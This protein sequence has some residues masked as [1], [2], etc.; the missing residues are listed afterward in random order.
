MIPGRFP[1]LY[2]S[3]ARSGALAEITYHWSLISPPPSKPVMVHELSV[4]TRK[5]V[6]VDRSDFAQ[7]GISPD[8]FGDRNYHRTQEIGAAAA[9]LGLDGLLVPSARAE[10]EN[11]VIFTENHSPDLELI[12]V[13]SEEVRLR[14]S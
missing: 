8:Q 9:F 5:T 6:R 4:E 14:F 10:A 12:L 11:L 2:T 7:L 13:S 1:T 3:T